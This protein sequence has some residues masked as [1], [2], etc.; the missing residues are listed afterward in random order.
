MPHISKRL[1]L[2]YELYNI[3]IRYRKIMTGIIIQNRLLRKTFDQMLLYVN[4]QK[5][6]NVLEKEWEILK[7]EK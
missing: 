5:E 6:M 2:F 7:K 3:P 4:H 1:L